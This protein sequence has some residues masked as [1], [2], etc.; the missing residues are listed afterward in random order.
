MPD[1]LYKLA[2]RAGKALFDS[3]ARNFYCTPF[4]LLGGVT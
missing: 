1:L 3:T 2:E 4:L